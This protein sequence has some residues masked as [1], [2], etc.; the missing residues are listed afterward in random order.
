LELGKD[1]GDVRLK[2]MGARIII[3]GASIFFFVPSFILLFFSYANSSNPDYISFILL[4][5]FM[6][7]YPL[8]M[9]Q[10]DGKEVYEKGWSI[11]VG[12]A[13]LGLG[14]FGL[15]TAR[16]KHAAIFVGVL[17]LIWTVALIRFV[18]MNEFGSN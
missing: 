16:P 18:G 17:V 11:V 4:T 13:T 3:I 6:G 14:I 7:T 9:W 5:P 15:I 10:A 12:L 1:I 2:G 8:P